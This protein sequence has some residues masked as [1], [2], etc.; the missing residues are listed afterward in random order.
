MVADP[1][2]FRRH[3]NDFSDISALCDLHSRTGTH[4][5]GAIDCHGGAEF[6]SPTISQIIILVLL[7]LID[8]RMPLFPISVTDWTSDWMVVEH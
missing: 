4:P 3:L 1:L 5:P 8:S 7:L 6:G 2:V